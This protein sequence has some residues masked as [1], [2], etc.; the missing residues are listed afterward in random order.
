MVSFHD[1]NAVQIIRATL[2]V[3]LP[4]LSLCSYAL[5]ADEAGTFDY[6]IQ[7]AGH[8]LLG[9]RYAQLIANGTAVLT[10]SSVP[11]SLPPFQQD[12]GCFLSS[13]DLHTGKVLWRRDVCSSS[14][15]A[16]Y[17]VCS[18]VP[19]SSF[20]HT[21]DSRGVLRSWDELNGH[22]VD[23][24]LLTSDTSGDVHF[25]I[26]RFIGCDGRNDVV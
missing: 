1:A 25:N 26:P 7:T 5:F 6:T 13:R 15:V 4:Y 20:I 11:N 8:G 19:K 3:F 14:K 24:R 16:N 12:G 18:R 21:L 10:S 23:N 2:F 9:V 22:L 17:A